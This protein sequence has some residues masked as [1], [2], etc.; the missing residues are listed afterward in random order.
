MAHEARGAVLL[1]SA[2]EALALDSTQR[3]RTLVDQLRKE[4]YLAITSRKAAILFMDSVEMREAQL[5]ADD[6]R[7]RFYARKLQYDQQQQLTDSIK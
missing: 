2:R 6:D 5:A 3:A 4:C 1:S 7:A